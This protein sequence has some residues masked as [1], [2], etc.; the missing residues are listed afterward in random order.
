MS[1]LSVRSIGDEDLEKYDQLV[2]NAGTVFAERRWLTLFDG[3]SRLLGLFD[4]SDRLV[5]A[6][7]IP[8]S[9]KMGFPITRRQP[10]TPFSGPY[11]SEQLLQSRQAFKAHRLFLSEICSFFT[12]EKTAFCRLS[13]DPSVSDA[14]PFRWKGYKVIPSY[15][16]R[17][18][19]EKSENDIRSGFSST[20]RR[21]IRAAHRDS[22]S[23]EPLSKRTFA[24][25]KVS[26]SNGLID[27]ILYQYA[28]P[29][30]SFA[31][32]AFNQGRPI[33]CVF[34]VYDRKSAYYLMGGYDPS[35]AHHGAGAACMEAAIFK[36]KS[37]G[38]EIFDFEGSIIP[39][40]ERYIQ[41]FG[42]RLTPYFTINR[43]WMPLE[44][45]LKFK[46]RAVF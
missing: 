42:G 46:K 44:I 27:R 38:L 14:L 8:Q 2:R 17:I 43:A 30:N 33:A 36:A 23:I 31:F 37:L 24:R 6:F 13:L 5:G 16:Y 20:R 32:A 39:A 7:P 4:G 3:K 12:R 15:T 29:S 18:W 10:F 45:L 28:S 25:Q 26:V 19:L 21:N 41:G 22:I 1:N 35:S 11:Y 34:C 40:I 9:K